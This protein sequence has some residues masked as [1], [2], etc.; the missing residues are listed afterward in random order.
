MK[1]ADRQRSVTLL[2]ENA[3]AVSYSNRLDARKQAAAAHHTAA[4]T[5]CTQLPKPFAGSNTQSTAAVASCTVAMR[6][7]LHI[8]PMT[9]HDADE[10]LTDT[11]PNC[12]SQTTV[13]GPPTLHTC[14]PIQK[15]RPVECAWPHNWA[16]KGILQAGTAATS[17]GK[18][19]AA[20]VLSFIG[21]YLPSQR[22]AVPSSCVERTVQIH[23]CC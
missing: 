3:S 4:Q 18:L 22:W 2:I 23:H 7:V 11:L 17:A 21:H 5:V 20:G 6:I 1:L 16:P 14:T 12:T 13:N 19:V 10:H 9:K 8:H 15:A